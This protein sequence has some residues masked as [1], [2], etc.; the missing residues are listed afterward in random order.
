MKRISLLGLFI[1]LSLPIFA[2]VRLDLGIDIPRGVGAVSGNEVLSDPEVN[3]FFTDYIFPL[4]EA[5]LYYQFGEHAFRA[6]VGIRAFT[7][8]IAT[9]YWPNAYME[10][11]LGPLTLTAQLGGGF[12]GMYALGQSRFE[13]GKVFLP[14]LSLWYRIGNSFRLG[15]GAIGVMLPESTAMGFLYYLGGKFNILFK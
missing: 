11:D 3:K 14:D 9:I 7:L 8:I 6:G 5:G 13:S 1:L 10:A 12:F 2:Q 15:G 4:P